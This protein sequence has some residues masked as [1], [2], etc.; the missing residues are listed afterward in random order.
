MFVSAFTALALSLAA[1]PDGK[2]K[3]FT[4]D[5]FPVLGDPIHSLESDSKGNL[6]FLTGRFA[7]PYDGKVFSSVFAGYGHFFKSPTDFWWQQSEGGHLGVVATVFHQKDGVQKVHRGCL[8]GNKFRFLGMDAQGNL[9]VDQRMHYGL[10][11]A[12]PAVIRLSDTVCD[13]V[14]AGYKHTSE[15]GATAYARD[16]RG[17]EYFSTEL[18]SDVISC[19]PTVRSDKG[20]LDTLIQKSCATSM[21][22]LDSQALV[23]SPQGL[24]LTTETGS[25]KIGPVK[26]LDM[27]N[28]RT[29]FRDSRGVIWLAGDFFQ[30]V[31]AIDGKDTVLFNETN[32]EFKSSSATSFGED[33]KGNVW[34]TTKSSTIMVFARSEVTLS[35]ARR[36]LRRFEGIG[37]SGAAQERDYLGRKIGNRSGKLPAGLNASAIR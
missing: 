27:K 18:V 6:Y 9:L 31:M 30:G 32:S 24:W 2:W 23:A 21:V 7:F 28:V 17:R 37:K 19:G 22:A 12:N 10:G 20:K 1:V 35:L 4:H 15:M 13:T 5:Q 36:A 34:M 29:L 3:S 26:G 8:S 11:T 16:G 33:A 14:Q 25:V